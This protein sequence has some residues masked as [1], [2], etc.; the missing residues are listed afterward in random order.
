MFG[1]SHVTFPHLRIRPPT[2]ARST[3]LLLLIENFLLIFAPIL[4]TIVATNP[5]ADLPIDVFFFAARVS[6]TLSGQIGKEQLV[7]KIS[8][9]FQ[10]SRVR[11]FVASN[12]KSSSN[13]KSLVQ[14]ILIST[15]SIATLLFTHQ[16]SFAQSNTTQSLDENYSAKIK[17]FTT[18]PFFLTELVDHLPSSSTVPTPEKVLGYVIG[19]PGRLS[20]VHDI[21][22]YMRKLEKSSPRVKVFSMGKSEEGREMILVAISDEQ[23]IQRLDHFKNITGQLSDPRKISEAQAQQLIA[24]GKPMYWASGSIHSP[25]TGSPEMLMELAYRLAV[26]ETPFIK[27]IRENLIV[28]MTPWWKPM[29]GT[30]RWTFTTIEETFQSQMRQVCFIGDIT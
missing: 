22:R 23:T 7:N 24:E 11:R 12:A 9:L 27:A 4:P 6:K 16:A 29:A 1:A 28:M 13:S 5:P 15:I 26:E 30:G 18:E 2:S 21:H 25:E 17:E 3:F 8:R 19:T 14:V 20:Y 10:R